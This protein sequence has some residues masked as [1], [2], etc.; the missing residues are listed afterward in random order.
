MKKKIVSYLQRLYIQRLI[1]R[2]CLEEIELK[3]DETIASQIRMNRKTTEETDLFQK[4]CKSLW[5]AYFYPQKYF[6]IFAGG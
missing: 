2:R 6:F 5:F 1:K 4:T 3:F